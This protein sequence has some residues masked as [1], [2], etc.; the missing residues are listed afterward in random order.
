VVTVNGKGGTVGQGLG[1]KLH[2][3]GTI[4]G[5][6]T[7]GVM[8]TDVFGTGGNGGS[9]P[10]GVDLASSASIT[11]YGGDVRVRGFAGAGTG[12]NNYGVIPVTATITS[13]GNGNVVVQGT[14]GTNGSGGNVGVI[15]HQG[16]GT[17]SSSGTGTVTVTG[18]GGAGPNSHGV[19]LFRDGRITSGSSGAVMVNGTATAGSSFGVYV[20]GADNTARINSGGGTITVT[21]TAALNN[22]GIVL[23]GGGTNVI[24]STSNGAITLIADTVA[25]DGTGLNSVNSGTGSTTLRQLTNGK[26][27]N[28]SGASDNATQLAF[29]DGELDRVTAGT[30]VLGDANSGAVDVTSQSSC[31]NCCRWSS[32]IA[33]LWL[34]G[35]RRCERIHRRRES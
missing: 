31:G 22:F 9:N 18:M 15:P 25:L 19:Q 4:R 3:G 10:H 13:G 33:G 2:N 1:V 20:N 5:G 30:L 6:T 29:T 7:A 34:R 26:T 23:G 11:S 14:G 12:A 16:N 32:G 35:W 8:T 17:I 21:G 28:L 24:A 27:I